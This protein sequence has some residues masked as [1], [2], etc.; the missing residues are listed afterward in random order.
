M[1][2][3]TGDLVYKS[4]PIYGRKFPLDHLRKLAFQEHLELGILN[5]HTDESY[6]NIT[7]DELQQRFK[8]T[9]MNTEDIKLLK[10]LERRSH[11]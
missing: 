3:I 8:R 6:T 2:K 11:I 7:N 9:G 10:F 4:I 1:D 5:Y